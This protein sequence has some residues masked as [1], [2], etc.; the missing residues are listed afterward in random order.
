MRKIFVQTKLQIKAE[1][2]I[3]WDFLNNFRKLDYG[4]ITAFNKIRRAEQR[5]LFIMKDC[6]LT[7]VGSEG[8]QEGVVELK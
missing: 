3:S 8:R 7:E 2:K 6:E 4:C 1:I 5:A